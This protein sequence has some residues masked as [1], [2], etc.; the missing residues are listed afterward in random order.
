MRKETAQMSKTGVI[1]G[2]NG[3]I[4]H[5]KGDPGFTMNEMVYVGK[6]NLVGRGS[7]V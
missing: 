6:D 4:I 2:I 3:P 1:Y 7:S 5:L